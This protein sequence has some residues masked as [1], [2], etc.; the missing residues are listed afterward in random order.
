MARV[1]PADVMLG[2][3]RKGV[4]ARISPTDEASAS[5]ASRNGSLSSL[6]GAQE[7]VA[8]PPITRPSASAPSPAATDRA[9]STAS[10][11]GVRR[12]GMTT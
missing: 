10:H 11:P 9:G 12:L 5:W 2:L 4:H 6:Y 3:S 1:R 8:R 7:R